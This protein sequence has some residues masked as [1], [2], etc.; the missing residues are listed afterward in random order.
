MSRMIDADAFEVFSYYSQEG[1]FDDG[2]RFVL[3]KID[4]MPTI[5]A[6][7]SKSKPVIPHRN[8]KNCNIY[9][10]DCGW[11]LKNKEQTPN[12]CPNCGNRIEWEKGAER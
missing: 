7:E 1:T 2:V 5:D 9:W 6:V 3:E 10:C 8:Y 12:Y 11:F 4:A